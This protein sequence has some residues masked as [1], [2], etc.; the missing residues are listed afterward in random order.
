MAVTNLDNLSNMTGGDKDTMKQFI[1]LYLADT[2]N[3]LGKLV[4]AFQNQSF[5]GV[6][7]VQWCAHKIAP[8]LGY[9]GMSS[10]YDL[11]KKIENDMLANNHE[12]ILEDLANMQDQITQSYT[13]LEA[14]LNS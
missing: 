8:Q 7:S 11:A 2:P 1:Q 5:Q 4:S 9:M 10:T 3:L 14:F 12:S 13:E 6:D